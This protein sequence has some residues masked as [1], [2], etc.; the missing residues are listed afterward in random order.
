M[1]SRRVTIDW[2]GAAATIARLRPRASAIADAVFL[3]GL[4]AIAAGCGW[5]YPPTAPI[6]GGGFLVCLA[7]LASR[8]DS[9]EK[10]GL[11]RGV[12]RWY[13]VDDDEGGER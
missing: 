10:P 9:G 2:R 13:S 12:E 8:D 3:A 4:A 7:W 5:I 11:T 1:V 6:V